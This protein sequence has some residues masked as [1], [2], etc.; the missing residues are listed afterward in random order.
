MQHGESRINKPPY[1]AIKTNFKLLR[2]KMRWFSNSSTWS[3]P[4]DVT[5]F[6][7]RIN[8]HYDLLIYDKAIDQGN[9]YGWNHYHLGER[10]GD[11]VERIEERPYK[12]AH[13]FFGLLYINT[14]G[15]YTTY[16]VNP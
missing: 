4:I 16:P 14:D 5:R 9:V 10:K 8:G 13:S 1:Q 11:K 12:W 3:N 2:S 15:N 6:Y 7:N